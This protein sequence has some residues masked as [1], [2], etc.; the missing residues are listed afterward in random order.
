MEILVE[1]KCEEC[2]DACEADDET[3]CCSC[4]GLH[5]EDMC[6]PCYENR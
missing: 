2:E 3:K 4:R 6:G 5:G 1:F